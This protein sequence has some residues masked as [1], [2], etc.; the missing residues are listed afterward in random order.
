MK[1]I[2]SFVLFL[3]SL[4]VS[5]AAVNIQIVSSPA[6][7]PGSPSLTA[8][9]REGMHYARFRSLT[10]SVFTYTRTSWDKAR[11]D[12]LDWSDIA[13]ST[14]GGK[15]QAFWII[16]TDDDGVTKHHPREFSFA[17][18]SSDPADSLRFVGNL[19]TNVST[20]T[21]LTFSP[22]TF[23]GVDTSGEL[24]SSGAFVPVHQIITPLRVWLNESASA[25]V[26]PY[27]LGQDPLGVTCTITGGGT[28]ASLTVSTAPALVMLRA[29][30]VPVLNLIGQPS[31]LVSYSVLGAE[32]VLPLIWLVEENSAVNGWSRSFTQQ[33]QRFFKAYRNE[34]AGLT[35]SKVAKNI[36]SAGFTQTD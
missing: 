30:G 34:A 33:P 25:P 24:H 21:E 32:N 4:M 12:I 36:P 11:Y 19:A 17:I 16:I 31:T 10:G 6:P 7:A 26:E 28:N 5:F 14:N 9:Y 15:R 35:G 18:H 23:L 1:T 8:Y 2:L 3:A 27:V 22:T 13:L 29:S 20:G